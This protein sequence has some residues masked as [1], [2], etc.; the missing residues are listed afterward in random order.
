MKGN[1]GFNKVESS[2]RLV[3]LPLKISPMQ[4]WAP[5]PCM[6]TGRGIHDWLSALV[7]LRTANLGSCEVL[8]MYVRFW[9]LSLIL[10]TVSVL[11]GMQA[12]EHVPKLELVTVPP[13]TWAQCEWTRICVSVG[14]KHWKIT[15]S[16]QGYLSFA[17]HQSTSISLTFWKEF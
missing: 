5:V 4:G 8:C 15:V 10:R 11:Q 9:R 3:D 2:L 14:I 17:L 13:I 1:Q 16:W 6:R 12:A 7:L